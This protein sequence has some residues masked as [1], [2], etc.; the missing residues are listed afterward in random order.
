MDTKLRTDTMLKGS[1]HMTKKTR[2]KFSD[3]FKDEAVKIVTDQGH[4]ATEAAR[5]LGVQRCVQEVDKTEIIR[6]QG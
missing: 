1:V 5:N 4:K 6:N 2:R 3:D